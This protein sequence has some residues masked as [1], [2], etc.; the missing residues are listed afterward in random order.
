[1][2]IG[3]LGWGFDPTLITIH[4]KVGDLNPCSS[5]MFVAV[6]F[7]EI[8]ADNKTG[9]LLNLEIIAEYRNR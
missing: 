7:E 3:L 4:L 8:A 9:V 2:R 1:L 6:R 5:L